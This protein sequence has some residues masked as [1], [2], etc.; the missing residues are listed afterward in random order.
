MTQ[1]FSGSYAVGNVNFTLQPT[2]GNW[3][4]RGNLGF[5]GNGHPIYPSVRSFEI[6][7]D[8]IHPTDAKQLIDSYN[9]ISNTGTLVFDLPEYGNANYLFKSYSGCTIQEPTFG[10][11]FQGY[12]MNGKLTINRVRT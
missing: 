6:Q 2:K 11:Y 8:L 9:T 4:G 3:E 7:W 5:D 1:G 12:L 10:D